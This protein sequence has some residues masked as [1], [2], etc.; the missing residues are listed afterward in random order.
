MTRFRT[1]VELNG[2]TATGIRVPTEVV[3]GFGAGKKP[4]V[5]VTI[6]SHSY[7]STVAVYNGHFM[8]ALS[9]ANRDAAGVH[10]GDTIEV[11]VELDVGERTV[12]VPDD[13]AAALADSPGARAAFDALSYTNQRERVGSVE[14]AKRIETRQRRI[15]RIV[16]G[17]T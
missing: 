11:D 17:L 2:K 14:G 10:A 16:D 7:R 9:A 8:L 1:E 15:S 12:A 4:S 13:L 5:M 6:G 3:D